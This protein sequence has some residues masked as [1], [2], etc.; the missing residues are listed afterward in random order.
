MAEAQAM[1]R[2]STITV[3]ATDPNCRQ[4]VYAGYTLDE[5]RGGKP[6]VIVRGD[7]K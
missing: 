6:A 2:M 3:D 7:S 1:L 4:R 5:L